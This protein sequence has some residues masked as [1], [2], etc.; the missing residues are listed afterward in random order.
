MW[1][2]YCP[3]RLLV[4]CTTKQARELRSEIE[5]R[6]ERGESPEEVLVWIKRNHGS[7]ALARPEPTGFGLAVWLVPAAIF[8]LGG[9]A[10]A[11]LVRRWTR[12]PTLSASCKTDTHRQKEITVQIAVLL[13]DDMTALDAIGPY[14]VIGRL[15]GAELVFVAARPRH[16]AHRPGTRPGRGP[17]ADRGP[18]SRHH[19]R[20]GRRRTRS[21]RRR[22]RPRLAPVGARD[23]DVDDVRLY[24][25][26]I[27]GA[28][29]ILKG[30][31]ATTHWAML[32]RLAEF[33]AKPVS[34]RVVEDGKVVTAA[35]VSAGID[36]G[37]TLAA[38]IAGDDFAQGIQ[39]G[40]EYDPQPPFDSGSP[41]KA[42]APVLGFLREYY[43]SSRS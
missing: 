19:R 29:G 36:M 42:S 8:V 40:I 27:L 7:E 28:A 12:A 38:R 37:L 17:R 1:S 18:D 15:P 13:Y 21:V 32:D 25:I 39:L 22:A 20:P 35:G 34:E 24:G 10:V 3:G 30:L 11:S 14:E 26:L 2:P 4:D 33:G 41:A 43:A 16:K 31:N 23:L 6:L 9:I 5:D